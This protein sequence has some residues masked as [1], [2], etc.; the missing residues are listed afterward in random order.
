M[1]KYIDIKEFREEG[2]LQELNRQFLHP[3]GLALEIILN[4]D[5][6]EKLGGI[7]DY[8]D[9]DEG[10]YYDLKKSR[11]DRIHQFK[12]KEKFIKNEMTI[13]HKERQHQLGFVV[14]PIPEQTLDWGDDV[15]KEIID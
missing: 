13:K 1:I 6:T 14:E 4:D 3:L 5:G 11:K 2:Y 9:Q 7:W 8:R 15:G 10:I 12:S